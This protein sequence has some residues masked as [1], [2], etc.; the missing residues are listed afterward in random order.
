MRP[1]WRSFWASMLAYIV[2]SAVAVLFINLFIITI[3]S[4]FLKNSEMTLKE[5]S[6]LELNLD[7]KINERSG[8]ETTNDFNNPI[9]KSYGIHEVKKTLETAKNDSKIKGILLKVDNVNL[10]LASIDELR[11]SLQDFKSSGKFI[12]AYAEA[13]SLGAFYL[14]S[15]A[16]QIYLYPEGMIDFR[17]LGSEMMF[18]KKALDKFAIDVQI[19]RGE[20]NIYKSAVE[21][22]MYE[23]MSDDNRLQ[24]KKLLDDVWKN[25]THNIKDSR[26]MPLENLNEIADS[27]YSYNAKGCLTHNLVDALIYEDELDSITRG[28]MGI[29]RDKSLQPI[30]FKKY[31]DANK[32]LNFDM[33]VAN[34]GNI[35]VVYAIGGIISGKSKDGSM[36]SHTIV[37]AINKAKNDSS[38]KAVV[39]RVNSPG[40][41]ALASDVIWRA[42]EMTKKEKP[43]IVSM[44][45]VAAS[46]GYYI[47]C[48]AEKI[49]AEPNTITG[50]I[51]VFGMI[52]NFGRMLDTKI[53]ITVD[54]VETNEHA[55]LT[56]F[57]PLDKKELSIY[58]K[59]VNE[60]YETFITK[61]AEGRDGLKK[62]DVNEVARGR[63]WS[64]KEALDLELVDEIG[65]L[66]D[67]INYAANSVKINNDA[68][69]IL[70]L[71]KRE[72]DELME[73]LASFD[74]ETKSEN[75][76]LDYLKKIN[77]QFN[78][79]FNQSIIQDRYQALFP[80]EIK[81]Q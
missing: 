38:I 14:N 60:I 55:T 8:I 4:A 24:I 2:L 58:Q 64:G 23:K 79:S 61:V 5:N 30:S 40:G 16:D 42:I 35:A 13:Y 29:E 25:M 68:I 75:E 7:F 78:R 77:H 12:I 65:N 21:P 67:A 3:S 54:R 45:D 43:V 33:G 44:G 53:G 69:K 36:G 72:N 56:P 66:Q 47:S 32:A 17:G 28:L 1:F 31:F 9:Q 41:S 81:L 20:G 6:Y 70:E 74:F 15:V 27:V 46:G 57:T 63:V 62:S 39:L 73:I 50:S 37:N 18:F 80:F 34:K 11:R 76:I 48:G 51:G 10:G 49:F 71:P 59:G 22:Y 26:N 19:I 52:P